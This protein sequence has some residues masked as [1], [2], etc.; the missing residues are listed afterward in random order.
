MQYTFD[1]EIDLGI[2]VPTI[3]RSITIDEDDLGDMVSGVDFD[4]DELGNAY[5]KSKA[6]FNEAADPVVDE[7]AET[8]EEDFA[9]NITVAFIDRADVREQLKT[10]IRR[11]LGL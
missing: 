11:K 9:T 8:M 7:M 3:A 10:F 2:G 6:K 5:E 1:I 4:E